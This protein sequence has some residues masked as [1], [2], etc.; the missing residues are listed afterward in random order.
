MSSCCGEVSSIYETLD[1][2]PCNNQYNFKTI[3]SA[4]FPETLVFAVANET[5]QPAGDCR[6]TM[7][8]HSIKAF[9]FSFILSPFQSSSTGCHGFSVVR[10]FCCCCCCCC[11]C[12]FSFSL[13]VWVGGL[14]LLSSKFATTCCKT[15]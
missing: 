14:S 11:C 10:V 5:S 3:L 4:F 9:S 6:E 7:E 13:C 1:T 12:F 15:T 2:A 8:T